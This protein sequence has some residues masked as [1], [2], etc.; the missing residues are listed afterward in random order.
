MKFD[1]KI[2]DAKLESKDPDW[3]YVGDIKSQK[4]SQKK[5]G[6]KRV[7]CE[8]CSKTFNK[9][10]WLKEHMARAH[11]EPVANIDKKHTCTA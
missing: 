4:N 5:T 10:S 11:K 9:V 6:N 1:R 7:N 2:L 3:N 8:I